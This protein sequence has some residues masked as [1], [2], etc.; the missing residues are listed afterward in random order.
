MFILVVLFDNLLH[1][2]NNFSW[3]PRCFFHF[4]IYFWNFGLLFTLLERGAGFWE[5]ALLKKP[6]SV[7]SHSCKN[8]EGGLQKW[9]LSFQEMRS[10]LSAFCGVLPAQSPL[11]LMAPLVFLSPCGHVPESISTKGSAV[12]EAGRKE[13][14]E[15]FIGPKDAFQLLLL[16]PFQSKLSGLFQVT[17]GQST[18]S[19]LCPLGGE[20][21]Q[22][23]PGWGQGGGLF[24]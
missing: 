24:L 6:S 1:L 3:V 7:Q 5:S 12:P 10:T 4:C 21:K 13:K 19:L 17:S 9:Y 15:V 2:Q 22:H 20:V 23:H 8:N 18:V 14:K 16:T 11:Q